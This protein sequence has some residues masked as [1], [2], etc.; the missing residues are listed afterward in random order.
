MYHQ[1]MLR[2]DKG[3]YSNLEAQ[4][5]RFPPFCII[6]QW[7]DTILIECESDG[8]LIPGAVFYHKQEIAY[9]GLS[10]N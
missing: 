3:R 7:A 4:D 6:I 9:G 2:L 10:Q 8:Q 1:L 5:I